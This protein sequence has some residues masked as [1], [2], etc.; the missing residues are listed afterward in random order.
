MRKDIDG[1]I[2]KRNLIAKTR[3]TVMFWVAGA[4]CALG[5][6][7]VVAFLLVQT[8]VFNQ[9]IIGMKS[10]TREVLRSN[11]EAV[12]DLEANIRVLNTNEELERVSLT[13]DSRPLQSILDALPADDNRLALGASLQ[14][15]LFSG[16]AG[17]TVDALSVDPSAASGQVLAEEG[18]DG[19]LQELPFSA[20]ISG[21]ANALSQALQR[22]EKS[23]R[24]VN[25]KT[26][27]ATSSGSNV[28]LQ[29]TGS[30]YYLPAQD[31]SLTTQEVKQ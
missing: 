13:T 30:A 26:I 4:S 16:V 18:L 5:A 27:N 6:V 31:L 21:D 15:K 3:K 8:I 7:L 28:S 20:S 24:A 9:K 29:I 25:V 22:L 19:G 1:I 17:L 23:I 11:I 10:E 12:P 14:Q 2:R